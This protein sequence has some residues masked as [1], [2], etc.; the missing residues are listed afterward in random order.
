MPITQ[1]APNSLLN[2]EVLRGRQWKLLKKLIGPQR[3]AP[4][5]KDILKNFSSWFLFEKM[6]A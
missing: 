1:I 6:I 5:N 3:T 2:H 4:T